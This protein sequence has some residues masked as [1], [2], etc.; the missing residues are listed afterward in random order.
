MS[1]VINA[2]DIVNFKSYKCNKEMADYLIYEKH[3][4]V[5]SLDK[6]KNS[7]KPYVFAITDELL[8]ALNEYFLSDN[9]GD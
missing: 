5:F 3:I 4:P 1:F 6:D 9:H 7:D 8:E 2:D